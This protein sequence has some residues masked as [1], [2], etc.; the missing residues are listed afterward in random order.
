MKKQECFFIDLESYFYKISEIYSS[1]FSYFKCI[2]YINSGE[3]LTELLE[4]KFNY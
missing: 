1:F 4:R 2:K 3:G